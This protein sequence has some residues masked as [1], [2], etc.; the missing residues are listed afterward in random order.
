M[1][2]DIATWGALAGVV[3][4]LIERAVEWRRLPTEVRQQSV[5]SDLGVLD[6]ASKLL[7]ELR[8]ERDDMRRRMIEMEQRLS[9][10]EL[11]V[12]KLETW[13]RSQGHDPLHIYD[14]PEGHPI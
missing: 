1:W 2:R 6:G 13:M 10:A 7:G 14:D 3:G 5:T 8:Q 12:F 11:K 4:M 9:T